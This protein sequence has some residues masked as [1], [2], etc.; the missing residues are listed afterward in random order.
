MTVPAIE[1]NNKAYVR[2]FRIDDYMDRYDLQKNSIRN[3]DKGSAEL[4]SPPGKTNAVSRRDLSRMILASV[5]AVKS[6]H[7]ALAVV[8]LIGRCLDRATNS[9]IFLNVP[10]RGISFARMY[11][12]R[13]EV[14]YEKTQIFLRRHPVPLCAWSDRFG[15]GSGFSTKGR[16]GRPHPGKSGRSELRR[17]SSRRRISPRRETVTRIASARQQQAGTAG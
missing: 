14:L 7:R 2:S 5:Q 17:A 11:Q 8:V 13:E 15:G 9:L 4:S 12:K 1:V 6:G 16:W 3:F 10:A